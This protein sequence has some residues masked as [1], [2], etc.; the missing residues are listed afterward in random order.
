MKTSDSQLFDSWSRTIFIHEASS[1]A[2][3]QAQWEEEVRSGQSQK[4]KDDNEAFVSNEMLAQTLKQRNERAKE[5][6]VKY[7]N[8]L[9]Q[10]DG[11]HLTENPIN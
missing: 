6:I 8:V 4:R 3:E 2:K 1:E 7:K 10:N 5:H 11:K 9:L